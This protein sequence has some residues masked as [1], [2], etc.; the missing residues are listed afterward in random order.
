MCLKMKS[1][2]ITVVRC[3]IR[4]LG[5]E[6]AQKKQYIKGSCLKRDLTVCKFR[7][8]L[9]KKRGGVFE[10]VDKYVFECLVGQIQ[11]QKSKLVLATNQ[12][13]DHT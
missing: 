12:K 9:V 8:C 4:F 6:W 1:F 5:G 7:G 10:G 11:V 13:S 3:K 2:N